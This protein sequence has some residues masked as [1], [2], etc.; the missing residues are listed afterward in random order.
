VEFT[1]EK[2]AENIE[3]RC[4]EAFKKIIENDVKFISVGHIFISQ[5]SET[6]S[7]G[8]S[9]LGTILLKDLVD[10]GYDCCVVSAQ[11]LCDC[12]FNFSDDKT[13]NEKL[14]KLIDYYESV[15]VLMITDFS[16]QFKA[17]SN[18]TF[19]VDKLIEFI[20]KRKVNGRYCIFCSSIH[21]SKFDELYKKNKLGDLI[22]ESGFKFE[23][24]TVLNKNRENASQK[25][26]SELNI[27]SD[28]IAP[29]KVE[30]KVEIE[31]KVEEKKEQ[32]S[33]EKKV[34]NHIF[35]DPIQRVKATPKK[36]MRK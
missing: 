27:L 18:S 5:K 11:E 28:Y 4:L 12:F 10:K 3:P 29:T 1:L 33:P 36:I 23:I 17:K 2:V 22:L 25:L 31:P 21:W 19:A 26:A 32:P 34:V 30:K 16:D 35:K 9:T 24:T 7:F 8:V 14:S 20:M 15:H 13:R 6:T